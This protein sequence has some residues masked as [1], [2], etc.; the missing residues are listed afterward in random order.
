MENLLHSQFIWSLCWTLI[1]SLW[2]ALVIISVVFISLKL[3][4]KSNAQLRYFI[5]SNALF[6]FLLSAA[7]TFVH[8]NQ[9][10][11]SNKIA[12][13]GSKLLISNSSATSTI[14][15]EQAISNSSNFYLLAFMLF[16]VCGILILSSRLVL[17]MLSLKRFKKNAELISDQKLIGFINEQAKQM[18]IFQKVRI[19]SSTL[20]HSPMTFGS[21]KPIILI[22]LSLLGNLSFQQ[23]ELILTH[24]LMHIKRKDYLIN[25]V[26]NFI[27]IVFFFNPIIWWLSKEIRKERENC[28]DDGVL[29][30]FDSL[31]YSK[32]LTQIEDNRIRIQELQLYMSASNNQN[33]LLN[34]IKRIMTQ[35]NHNQK[36]TILPKL[37]ICFLLL[38]SALMI[39]WVVPKTNDELADQVEQ[40]NEWNDLSL[41]AIFSFEPALDTTKSKH[42]Q[43][44][45]EAQEELV[46]AQEK[47]K[48]IQENEL[49]DVLKTLEEER[50]TLVQS[51]THI[52][53]EL[54]AVMA[55]EENTIQKEVE[56]VRSLAILEDTEEQLLKLEQAVAQL[57]RSFQ[58]S[59]D[60]SIKHLEKQRK[61]AEMHRLDAIAHE[62]NAKRLAQEAEKLKI[63]SEK[64][65]AESERLKNQLQLIEEI[66]IEKK[67]IKAGEKYTFQ[68]SKKKLMINNKKQS[69]ELFELFRSLLNEEE[70]QIKKDPQ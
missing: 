25:L 36:S 19:Y 52:Q 16:W 65:A 40:E 28:C 33:L 63:E 41:P 61:L 34:R 6:I 66:L 10:A 62:E 55:A 12:L 30:L 53:K 48:A 69:Q 38:S 3:I 14:N 49:K 44:L 2:Q 7:V 4:S 17:G 43:S 58:H 21:L 47:L 57:D 8:L 46:K 20:V 24:E 1:H 54:D 59:E 31:D 22:P 67:I 56:L 39:S 29:E 27:E 45:L 42:E 64:I 26:Q 32:T 60:S 50:R 5:L 23:L 51:E 37:I 9:D 15:S 11:L 18:G 68:M 70:Y 35:K 13:E